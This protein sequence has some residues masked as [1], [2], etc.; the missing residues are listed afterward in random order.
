MKQ[1]RALLMSSIAVLFLSYVFSWVYRRE[2]GIVKPMANLRYFYY[3]Q[4]IPD[5][6]YDHLTPRP[7]IDNLL[8]YFYF[9][10]YKPYD[11]MQKIMTGERYDVHWSDR[12]D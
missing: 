7:P 10:L 8:Y 3:V 12:R 11:V 2:L 6:C 9:P 5:C 4:S 1:R